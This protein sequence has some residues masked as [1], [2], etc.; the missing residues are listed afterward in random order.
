MVS[1]CGEGPPLARALLAAGWQVRVSVVSP[2]ATRAYGQQANLELAIGAI[3]LDQPCVADQLQA[4]RA[5]GDP[6]SWVIDASHPF[7]SRISTHL[8]QACNRLGQPLL[9]L[10]R[11]LLPPGNAE[12]LTRPQ[13]LKG[14]CRRGERLLLA[15]GARQLSLVRRCCPEA[16]LHARVLPRPGALRQA[17]AAGLAPERLVALQPQPDPEVAIPLE[18]ALCRRWRIETVLLRRSGGPGEAQWLRLA[19][20]QGLRLLLLERPGESEPESLSLSYEALLERLTPS[21]GAGIAWSR[22]PV[23]AEDADAPLAGP[24]VRFHGS[25]HSGTTP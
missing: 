20:R 15:I 11:P 23:P 16:C 7:A 21:P 3:G 1:G 5:A 14:R 10:R 9:R 22:P 24:G 17:L 18:E 2:E 25:S 19:D 6:F 12:L 8:S 13:D 4:A